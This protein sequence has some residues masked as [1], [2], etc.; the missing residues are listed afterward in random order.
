MTRQ[1][2]PS[3]AI[4][5]SYDESPRTHHA[6]EDVGLKPSGETASGK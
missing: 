6:E 5:K 4:G 1:A 2:W 3:Q